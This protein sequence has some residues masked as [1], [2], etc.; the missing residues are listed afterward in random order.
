M[1]TDEAGARRGTG[2]ATGIRTA[3]CLALGA[4]ALLRA[5]ANVD[6]HSCIGYYQAWVAARAVAL[7]ETHDVYDDGE[8]G[9]LEVLYE[10]KIVERIGDDVEAMQASKWARIAYAADAIYT[11]S[12]PWLYALVGLS[13]GGDYDRDLVLFQ[14]VSLAALVIACAWTCRRLGHSWARAALLVGALVYLYEP[15]LSD[16]AVGNVNRL[17]LAGLLAAVG[18]GAG[19][20]GAARHLGVGALLAAAVMFKPNAGPVVLVLVLAWWVAGE[21]RRIGLTIAGGALGTAVA[22]AVSSA[23][24]GSFEPWRRWIEELGLLM[25]KGIPSTAT[26]NMAPAQIVK[27]AEGAL[28]GWWPPPAAV[29]AALVAAVVVA[30]LL[31]RRRRGAAATDPAQDVTLAGL[32]GAIAVLASPLAWLHYYVLTVPLLLSLLRPRGRATR[33]E[34]LAAGLATLAMCWGSL[35]GLTAALTG[36]DLAGGAMAEHRMA[37]I[38]AAVVVFLVLALVDLA[39]GGDQPCRK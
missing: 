23:Y 22:L 1:T 26:G 18:W 17:V 20:T 14:S 39:R 7:G 34:V 16:A 30:V 21:R 2:A 24:F 35:L 4:V 5:G 38:G 8:R 6:R 19:G 10:A 12:T 9:R 31:G 25:G 33:L 11:F 32:G 15:V 28:P 27:D 13:S 36:A 29:A 37:R 3:L